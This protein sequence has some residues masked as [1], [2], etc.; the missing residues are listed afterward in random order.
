[1]HKIYM[2]VTLLQTHDPCSGWHYHY[3]F[4]YYYIIKIIIISLML[5]DDQLVD[6]PVLERVIRQIPTDD[7]RYLAVSELLH[8][9][10]QRIR[11]ARY[12]HLHLFIHSSIY[13]VQQ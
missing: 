11:L 13:D 12:V 9:Y 5:L 6:V 8:G 1:M 7:H 2:Y 3:Y 10:L 4:Y